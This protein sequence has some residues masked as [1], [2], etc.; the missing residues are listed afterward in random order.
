M[1]HSHAPPLSS[2]LAHP[3]SR[4]AKA[5]LFGATPSLPKQCILIELAQAR[6]FPYLTASASH[7]YRFTPKGI[8]LFAQKGS[9]FHIRFFLEAD[10]KDNPT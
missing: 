3:G 1:A 10:E 4:P 6:Q 9:N 2:P 8:R 7:Q 5:L